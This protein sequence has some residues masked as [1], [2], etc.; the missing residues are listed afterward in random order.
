MLLDRTHVEA[1]DRMMFHVQD[2]SSRRSGPTAMTLLSS[3]TDVTVALYSELER[4][5]SP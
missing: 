5:W 4:P 1:D 2:M 3:D